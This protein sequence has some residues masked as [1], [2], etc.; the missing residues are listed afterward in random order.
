MK[1]DRR[2][3]RQTSQLALGTGMVEKM[4]RGEERKRGGK[5]KK[6]RGSQGG[7]MSEKNS[8]ELKEL[9][10]IQ[11]SIIYIWILYILYML[12]VHFQ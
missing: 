4:G 2:E 12:N 5:R 8:L 11:C 1:S 7:Q 6:E 9:L 10:Y 3:D